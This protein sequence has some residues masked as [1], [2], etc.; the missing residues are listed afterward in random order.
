MAGSISN[1]QANAL[2]DGFFD[3]IGSSK[4]E[5]TPKGSL[6]ALYQLA[7]GLVSD[8]QR[9]LISSDRIA[10]GKLSDSFKVLNPEQLGKNIVVDIEA[11]YHYKFIIGGVR[12]TRGGSGEFSFKNNSVGRKMQEAIRK[13]LIK[14]GLK[15]RTTKKYKA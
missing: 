4:D 8:A 15:A 13:W 11:L 14:E 10:S 12:G 9:N 1:A 7:G 3:S 2:A 6:S 5:L